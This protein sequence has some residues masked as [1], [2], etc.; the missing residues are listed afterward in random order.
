MTVTKNIEDRIKKLT[1]RI[2]K[3]TYEKK[4]KLLALLI[5][6]ETKNVSK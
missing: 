4:A 2:D 5:V 1:P 3:L 6:Q